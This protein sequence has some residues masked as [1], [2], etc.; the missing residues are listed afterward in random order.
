MLEYD[1]SVPL[2]L[3]NIQEWF[4]KIITSPLQNNLINPISPQKTPINTEAAKYIVPSPT[5]DPGDRIQIYNQQYWWRLLNTLHDSFPLVTR[6]LGY[7]DF[8]K[9]IGVPYLKKY[10]PQHWSINYLGNRLPI[11]M[12]NEYREKDKEMLNEAVAIDWA[13]TDSFFA[14]EYSL[15]NLKDNQASQTEENVLATIFHLQPHLHLMNLKHHFFPFRDLILEQIPEYWDKNTMPKIEKGDYF[16]VIYR[17]QHYNIVWS[18]IKKYE[19]LLLSQFR[20]GKSIEQACQFL[21]NESEEFQ[22]EASR[23]L[24][25]WFQEWVARGWFGIKL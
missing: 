23:N 16:F 15:S 1:P 14:G 24:H 3:K 2:S 11:W 9:K 7:Y 12:K 25:L 19:F 22:L 18:E 17:N 6:I 4:S 5:L 21:E 20:D 10:P 13:F 8:N